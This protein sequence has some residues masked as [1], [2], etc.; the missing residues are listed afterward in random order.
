MPHSTPIPKTPIFLV[1]APS[2]Q[3]HSPESWL[4]LLLQDFPLTLNAC[5]GDWPVI[6]SLKDPHYLANVMKE[7]I[8]HS[9]HHL[10]NQ[11]WMKPLLQAQS[12]I[13]MC[14]YPLRTKTSFSPKYSKI[15]PSSLPKLP[16]QYWWDPPSSHGI[17]WA[18]S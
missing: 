2:N 13:N 11:L 4:E 3:D 9:V 5:I 18:L 15:Y 17:P 1:T 8:D 7:A 12:L 14:I 16:M 6:L 10:G